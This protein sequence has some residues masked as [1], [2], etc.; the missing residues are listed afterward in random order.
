MTPRRGWRQRL[1]QFRD[2]LIPL[3][4]ELPPVPSP[5]CSTLPA[6]AP[7]LKQALEVAKGAH[8]SEEE[9]RSAIQAKASTILG[10]IGAGLSLLGFR[11]DLTGFMR[12]LPTPMVVG[13]GGMLLVTGLYLL[14]AIVMA[15]RTL[16]V[17]PHAVISLDNMTPDRSETE[18]AYLSRLTD[19]YWRVTRANIGFNNRLAD[20]LILAQAYVRNALVSLII[21]TL[22]F[23]LAI[24]MAYRAWTKDAQ[25]ISTNEW[26]H[27]QSQLADLTRRLVVAESG[28]QALSQQLSQLSSRIVGNL[29]IIEP[30]RLVKTGERKHAVGRIQNRDQA[31]HQTVSLQIFLQDANGVFA[32]AYP[33]MLD[34]VTPGEQ[35]PFQL[36]LPAEANGAETCT[37][38]VTGV[39]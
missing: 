17:S 30:C 34:R 5:T 27:V 37:V 23:G 14:V 15:A 13:A 35:R 39:F 28:E 31:G 29:E 20:S 2:M 21:V 7:A 24:P 16:L 12:T 33:V 4:D 18:P 11:S 26:Q 6:N 9:R 25:Q 8:K 36:V 19:E 22:I 10:F 38:H 32:G 3:L 1:H